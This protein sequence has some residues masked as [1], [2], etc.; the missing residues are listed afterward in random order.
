MP[1]FNTRQRGWNFL[2]TPG[3]TNIPNRVLNAMN[4]PVVEFWDRNS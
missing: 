4:Q 3:P 1:T 2:Q